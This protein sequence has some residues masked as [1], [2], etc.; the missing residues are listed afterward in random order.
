MFLCG[1]LLCEIFGVMFY[2]RGD[3]VI[4]IIGLD[5]MFCNLGLK[6]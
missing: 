4:L 3:G 2:S 5:I 1:E 6:M